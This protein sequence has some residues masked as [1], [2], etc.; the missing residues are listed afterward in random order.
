MDN[1]MALFGPEHIN[2]EAAAA[3]HEAKTVCRE[4]DWM[5]SLSPQTAKDF[6]AVAERLAKRLAAFSAS[7]LYVPFVESLAKALLADK[8]VAEVRKVASALSDLAAL[9]QKEKAAAL[10]KPAPPTL[11]G[12]KKAGNKSMYE[13]F[14]D[15]NDDGDGFD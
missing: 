1:A 3:T 10:K 9:K 4:V 2:T 11:A 13:D 6:D 8:E 12:A 14:G 15:F 7:K 5:D